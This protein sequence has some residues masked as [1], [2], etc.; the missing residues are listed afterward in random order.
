M[1][2]QNDASYMQGSHRCFFSFEF[3]IEC[4]M[5]TAHGRNEDLYQVCRHFDFVLFVCFF[6]SNKRLHA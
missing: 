5:L 4:L 3:R 6:S 1:S 2:A